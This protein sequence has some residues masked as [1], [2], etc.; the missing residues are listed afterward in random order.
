MYQTTINYISKS[1]SAN[2]QNVKAAIVGD[3]K[4]YSKDESLIGLGLVAFEKSVP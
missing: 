3:G 1:I 2:Y 4:G